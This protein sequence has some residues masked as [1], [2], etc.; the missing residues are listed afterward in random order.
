MDNGGESVSVT[1]RCV[2]LEDCLLTGCAEVTESGYQVRPSSVLIKTAS[3]PLTHLFLFVYFFTF[4]Q[5]C[6]SCC[7]G[8]ICNMLVPR[9]ESSAVFS[10][11]SPLSSAGRGLHPAVLGYV[12]AGVILPA[13]ARP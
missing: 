11:A 2:P 1:K 4:A 3:V 12:A 7:E 6:S 13:A 10:S 8:N 5:M 9:N